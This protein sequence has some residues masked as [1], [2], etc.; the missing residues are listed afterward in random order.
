MSDTSGA[1]WQKKLG[2]GDSVTF[3]EQSQFVLETVPRMHKAVI[4]D[5]EVSVVDGMKIKTMKVPSYTENKIVEQSSGSG[6]TVW[7]ALVEFALQVLEERNQ[8]LLVRNRIK[9]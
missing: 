1:D 2:P 5:A 6:V 9:R 3:A 4:S 7:S 8:T